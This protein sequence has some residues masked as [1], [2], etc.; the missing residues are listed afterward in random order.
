MIDQESI[1]VANLMDDEDGIS[2]FICNNLD[3]VFEKYH[4]VIVMFYAYRCCHSE[5]ATYE[6]MKLLITLELKTMIKWIET[7]IDPNAMETDGKVD[8]DFEE[9]I[10]SENA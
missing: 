3:H 8:D 2:V 10:V 7:M 4:C 5:N 6:L 9:Q 1:V